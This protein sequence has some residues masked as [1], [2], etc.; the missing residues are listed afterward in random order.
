MTKGNGFPSWSFLTKLLANSALHS[1]KIILLCHF[2]YISFKIFFVHNKAFHDRIL[3]LFQTAYLWKVKFKRYS[4]LHSPTVPN[5]RALHRVGISKNAS[6]Y[7]IKASQ[8]VYPSALDRDNAVYLGCGRHVGKWLP[9]CNGSEYKIPFKNE[10]IQ[11][12]KYP[13]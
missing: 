1:I 13:L 4:S 11:S 8:K 12:I 2:I 7:K 6:E 9:I 3:S 5:Y 10:L